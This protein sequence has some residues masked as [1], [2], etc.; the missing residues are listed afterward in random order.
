MSLP[1]SSYPRLVI[2]SLP[3]Q[4]YPSVLVPDQF[5]GRRAV[6]L[7]RLRTVDRRVQRSPG[8]GFSTMTEVELLTPDATTDCF[9]LRPL[10]A[11]IRSVPAPGFSGGGACEH[12]T[13][14]RPAEGSDCAA[15]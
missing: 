9:R 7:E 15:V 10:G 2:S 11:V 8:A 5:R 4:E 14:I 13:T 12:S 1:A 3:L 6:R